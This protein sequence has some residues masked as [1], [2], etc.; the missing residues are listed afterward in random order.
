[1][2]QEI[3]KKLYLP[4]WKE[5]KYLQL[6]VPSI[7]ALSIKNIINGIEVLKEYD[8]D[9]YVTISCLRWRTDFLKKLLEFLVLNNIN[10]VTFNQRTQCYGLNPILS[11][12]KRQLKKRYN[13]DVNDIEK[14]VFLK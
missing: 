14:G 3:K 5:N 12:E 13:I 6:L 2:I 1:M 9:R 8:I 4:Y 7:F 11:C 10:L